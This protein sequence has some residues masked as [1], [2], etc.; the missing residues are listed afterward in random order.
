MQLPPFALDDWLNQY[1]FADPPVEFDLA[2]STGPAW[3]VAELLQLRDPA[4][5]D[6]LPQ[7][8]LLYSP[9]SGGEPLRAAIAQM[10]GVGPDDVQITTGASEALLILFALSAEPGA[11]VILPS[12]CF[13][14]TIALPRAFG[15]EVRFYHHRPEDEFRI[16]LEEVK[17]LADD[18]TRLLLINTPHNPTGATLDDEEVRSLH[19]F[20]AE[21]GI[22]FVSDEVYHPIYHGP[23]TSS[24]SALPHATVLGSF[25]KALSLSGLRVGWVIDRDAQ[26]R[27]QFCN[28]REYFTISN[29]AMSE[30][31]A[32]IAVC[33]HE[34]IIDRTRQV[35]SANLALLEQFFTDHKDQ[36]G[37]V[38]PPGGTMAFP[39]LL[40]GGPARPFCEALAKS[41]VLLAPGD[42]FERP[43]HFRIGFG[44]NLRIAAALERFADFLRHQPAKPAASQARR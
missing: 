40:D 29:S 43:S 35:S 22:Q 34:T 1:K 8:E 18:K 6:H 24:A 20:A 9:S 36:L 26:R 15:L 31:L 16:D 10:Q 12:P 4:A 33:N 32:E 41:G 2:S 5:R 3:T 23:P 28:A 25:S 19:D 44:A 30:A 21:R 38:R 27:R 13:P 37:W 14:P 17:S 11:N 42:C 7:L 39:W